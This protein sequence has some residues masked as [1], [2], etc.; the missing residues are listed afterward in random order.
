MGKNNNDLK[1]R[2][3]SIRSPDQWYETE[4]QSDHSFQIPS[5]PTYDSILVKFA[6]PSPIHISVSYLAVSEPISSMGLEGVSPL[7]D[8]PF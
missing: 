1:K 8:I 3:T 4:M 2:N 5:K 6:V 7:M